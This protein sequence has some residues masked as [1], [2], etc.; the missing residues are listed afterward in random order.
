MRL[1]ATIGYQNVLFAPT[2]N[3]SAIIEALGAA[4]IVNQKYEAGQTLYVS[5]H[6]AS[7]VEI[8][9]IADDSLSLPD[10]VR[11]ESLD[12]LLEIAKER[13]DLKVKVYALEQQ[14]K[15]FTDAVK[16]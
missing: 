3:Y 16:A 13:D 14:V 8:K 6:S 2:A 15:K 5:D 11:P 4:Q 9:L 7:P 1:L 10:V 12:K